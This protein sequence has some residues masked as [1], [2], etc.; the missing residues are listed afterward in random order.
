MFY[1]KSS[2]RKVNSTIKSNPPFHRNSSEMAWI[3]AGTLP[4]TKALD[5]WHQTT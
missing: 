1:L 5:K 4:S 2:E 3:G